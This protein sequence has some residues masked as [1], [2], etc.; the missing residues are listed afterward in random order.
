MS[1]TFY[2]SSLKGDGNRL[3]LH[4]G[5]RDIPGCIP[6]RREAVSSSIVKSPFDTHS[7]LAHT[8]SFRSVSLIERGLGPA[9]PLFS[10]KAKCPPNNSK[11]KLAKVS[12]LRPADPASSR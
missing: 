1:L 5:E 7:L 9:N 6:H 10:L 12:F 2:G 3:R 11:S 8:Y 4:R